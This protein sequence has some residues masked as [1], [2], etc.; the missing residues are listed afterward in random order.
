M[1]KTNK[2]QL[3]AA[4]THIYS[5]AHH[6]NTSKVNGNTNSL[7]F[8]KLCFQLRNPRRRYIWNKFNAQM[9]VFLQF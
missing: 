8:H 9:L 6:L 4:T 7:E 1:H 5:A 3:R 2:Q